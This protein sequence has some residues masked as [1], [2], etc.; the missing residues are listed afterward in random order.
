MCSYM[1][2]CNGN[3]VCN[4]SGKCDCNPGYKFADCSIKTQNLSNGFIKTYNDLGPVWYSF[5]FHG[6]QHNT[7][8]GLAANNI[9]VDVYVKKGKDSNPHSFNYDMSFKNVTSINLY[10]F[11]IVLGDEDGY[12]IAMYVP[13]IDYVDNLLLDSQVAIKFEEHTRAVLALRT[14]IAVFTFITVLF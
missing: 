2:N 10:S 11:D 8:L 7:K 9:G 6:S 14:I 12:S 3:G 1:S 4:D 13:A 5:T